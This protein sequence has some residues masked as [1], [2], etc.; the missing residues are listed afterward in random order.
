MVVSPAAD[1]ALLRQ[2]DRHPAQWARMWRDGTRLRFE[3]RLLKEGRWTWWFRPLR[4]VHFGLVRSAIQ[5]SGPACGAVEHAP[6]LRNP[7][8]KGGRDR[9]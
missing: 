4:K 1:G 2:V 6:P 5:R 3:I 7:L 9:T 8:M